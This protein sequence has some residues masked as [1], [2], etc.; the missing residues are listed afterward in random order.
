VRALGTYPV[1]VAKIIGM[2][3]ADDVLE[4]IVAVEGAALRVWLDGGWGVD[5]LLG[6][7]HREHSDLDLVVELDSVAA[8]TRAVDPLGFTVAEDQLPTRLVLRAPGGRQVDLHPVTFDA[9]GTGWQSAAG[10]DGSDCRYPADG[11]TTGTVRGRPVGCLAAAIQMEHHRG[12]EPSN[13]DRHD[14]WLLH[15]ALGTALPY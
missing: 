13:T 4:V 3:T 11:F 5:A 2:M 10:P 6:A 14:V 15:K 9:D 8:L 12:Y 7:Q 1:R